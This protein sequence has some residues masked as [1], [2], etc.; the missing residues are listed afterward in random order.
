MGIWPLKSG[1]FWN[2]DGLK[3]RMPYFFGD[4]H[5]CSSFIGAHQTTRISTKEDQCSVAATSPVGWWFFRGFILSYLIIVD[6]Q[7]PCWIKVNI[8]HWSFYIDIRDYSTCIFIFDHF[9]ILQICRSL[10]HRKTIY[11]DIYG[12]IF[13]LHYEHCLEQKRAFVVFHGYFHE[14]ILLTIAPSWQM[15]NLS[16]FKN[17]TPQKNNDMSLSKWFGSSK[18]SFFE[19]EKSL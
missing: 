16:T 14:D 19:L 2:G 8:V 9:R 18:P 12:Q 11:P 13:D 17:R 1:I 3:P 10:F 4:K 15:F 5:P 7:H 6:Y